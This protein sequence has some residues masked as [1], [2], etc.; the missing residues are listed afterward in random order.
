[1]RA[2][3][4]ALAI[5]AA[6]CGGTE[7]EPTV[8]VSHADRA[9][10]PV[11]LDL[12]ATDGSFVTVGDLRGKPTILFCF[13][14]Y[15]GVSQAAVRPLSRFVRHHPEVYVLAIATQPNPEVFAQA[16]ESALT[17]GFVVTFDPEE[18]VIEGTTDLGYIGA[19]PTYILLD[20]H[21]VEVERYTGFASQ[22]Q[23]EALLAMLDGGS[24]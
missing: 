22:N 13:A 7:D 14:T 6:A 24:N 15:D 17:P 18:N 4:L 12:R 1:M 10:G 21:G 9:P 8:G 2:L 3:V 16:W 11:E 19:V 5:A 23:L 20:E